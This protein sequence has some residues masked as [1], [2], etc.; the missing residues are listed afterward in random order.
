MAA[1]AQLKKKLAAVQATVED[2]KD[3]WAARKASVK[4]GFLRELDED[5]EVKKGGA[6]KAV[7]AAVVIE[8]ANSD[9]SDEAVLVDTP[10]QAPSAGADANV[11]SV[12][13]GLR[14]GTGSVRGKKKKGKK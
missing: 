13:D 1:N 7:A 3:W 11:D 5:E 8:K 10:E 14:S 9:G 2:E 6:K 4:E 12:G